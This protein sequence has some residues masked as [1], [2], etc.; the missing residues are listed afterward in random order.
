[1]NLEGLRQKAIHKQIPYRIREE[2]GSKIKDDN[3]KGEIQGENNPFI[4][5]MDWLEYSVEAQDASGK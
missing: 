2:A 5:S 1:M 3:E 4:N